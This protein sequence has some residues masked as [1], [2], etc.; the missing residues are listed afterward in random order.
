MTPAKPASASRSSSA[1]VT[2]LSNAAIRPSPPAGGPSPRTGTSSPQESGPKPMAQVSLSPCQ[3][4]VA[5]QPGSTF[6]TVPET[7]ERMLT[8]RMSY[9]MVTVPAFRS[10]FLTRPLL[11]ART[12]TPFDTSSA[13]AW[14]AATK[15]PSRLFSFPRMLRGL[16]PSG[17][18]TSTSWGLPS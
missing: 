11:G 18:A 13:M 15:S 14:P 5:D 9:W 8:G 16:M 7:M 17:P 4:M 6:E 10:T 1:A 12:K 3:E 2:G